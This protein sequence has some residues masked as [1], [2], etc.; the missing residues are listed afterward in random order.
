MSFLP[1]ISMKIVHNTDC[2]AWKMLRSE[3]YNGNFRV[4]RVGSLGF[5]TYSIM[6]SEE[7]DALASR[8]QTPVL[9]VPQENEWRIIFANTSVECMN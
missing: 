4:Y 6:S 5:H 3:R 1:K 8:F 2:H 7:A 9:P